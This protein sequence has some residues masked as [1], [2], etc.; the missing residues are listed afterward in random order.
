MTDQKKDF[1]VIMA[2]KTIKNYEI[3]SL[4]SV[5]LAHKTIGF[6]QWSPNEF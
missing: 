6:C 1:K 5:E 3:C 4:V 2:N